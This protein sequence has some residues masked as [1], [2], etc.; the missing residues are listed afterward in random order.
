MAIAP[1]RRR[2][3]ASSTTTGLSR[4]APWSACPSAV[5]S[6]HR[7]ASQQAGFRALELTAIQQLPGVVDAEHGPE[8]DQLVGQRLQPAEHATSC[9]PLRMAGHRPLD[10]VRRPLEV[11]AGQRVADRLGPFA[12]LLVPVARPPVQLGRRGRAAR[13]A[14]APA[15]RRQRDGDSDTT[16]GGRRA[17]PGTGS[18]RSRASSMALPP[19]WPVT[20]SHSGP[21]SRSRIGGLQQE[22]PDIVRADAAGPLRPGSR[23]CSGRRRRSRR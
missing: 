8:R 18:P 9:R 10:Q 4:W 6:S 15:A 23:R 17:G 22:A 13:P 19:S 16:G 3:S 20:A 14:G 21:L 5:V 11:L 12:V 2:N 1:G 7:S